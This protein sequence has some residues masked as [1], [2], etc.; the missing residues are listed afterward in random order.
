M[1]G[2]NEYNSNLDV[3]GT[4]KVLTVPNS[5]G[6]VLTYNSVSKE[7]STRTNAEIIVDLGL[8]T[9]YTA[10][11]H[12]SL[13]SNAITLT[14][15]ANVWITDS[16]SKDR[17]Y[18]GTTQ[19]T[20]TI[21]KLG[22]VGGV[23]SIKNSADADLFSVNSA[24]GTV[25]INVLSG[26]GNRLIQADLSGSIFATNIDPANVITT[27]NIGTYIPPSQTLSIPTNGLFSNQG[28]AISISSGN[29]VNLPSLGRINLVD[30]NDISALGSGLA[31]F[32]NS[33]G[34]SN[35]PSGGFGAG[36]MVVRNPSNNAGGNFA[37]WTSTGNV[38]E[39]KL[40][41]SGSAGWFG[42]E[43]VATRE[44][45][46]TQLPIIGNGNISYTGTGNITGG[47]LSTANQATNTS[48]TFDLTSQT[49]IDISLGVTA[50]SW[51]RGLRVEGL[52]VAIHNSTSIDAFTVR[53]SSVWAASGANRPNGTNSAVV[54]FT[55]YNS[56]GT[57]YGF[58]LGARNGRI[59]FVTEE[60]SVMSSW[61]ELIHA[62]NIATQIANNAWTITGNQSNLSGV[63]T[64]SGTIVFNGSQA[65]PLFVGRTGTSLNSN[66]AFGFDGTW[67]AYVGLHDPNTFV[68]GNSASMVLANRSM[69][70]DIPSGLLTTKGGF[71]INGQ[72]NASILLAG[73][74]Y[75]PVSDF[76]LASSVPAQVNLIQ[77]TG[78][79]ITG[80]Y[81]NLTISSTTLGTVTSVGAS[82]TG[83]ALSIVGSP[84]TNS[85]TLAFSWTGT[86]SQYVDGTGALVNFPTIPSQLVYTGSNGINVTGT[87]ISP[88]YG[89][90]S[91]TVAE[92]ND[93]RINNG[94]TAF[95][96][97]NHAGLYALISHIHTTAQVT[98]LTGYTIGTNVAI[99]ATD[100]LNV[101]LGKIQAQLN[102]K[103]SNTGTVTS[104]A[105]TVAGNAL[106]VG[107]S[108]IITSGT[109]AFT[110]AGTTSQYVDGSGTL[111][112]FPTIPSQLVYTGSNG[113]NVTGTVISPVYGTTANTVA[114][115]NDSRFH[116][117]VT[118]GT[119]NG[120]SLSTQVL[121]LALATTTTAG[122]MSNTD[123]TKLD[124]IASN[125]NN[126]VLPIMTATVAGG[127][128]VFSNT[129]QT[130][131][132][133]AV[134]AV[135]SRTYGV[136]LNSSNQLVVNI[137]WTNTTYASGTLTDLNTGTS[138]TAVLWSPLIL[139]QWITAKLADKV[140]KTTTI[141]FNGNTQNLSGNVNFTVP[142]YVSTVENFVVSSPMGINPTATRTRVNILT[143]IGS[144]NLN[145][146]NGINEGDELVIVTCGSGGDF[147]INMEVMDNCN[148]KNGTQSIS[149]GSTYRFW[150]SPQD[151]VWLTV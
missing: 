56:A 22:Q 70:L 33:V 130:V 97:G 91:G 92:G 54:N 119:A 38:N 138:T 68:I 32:F 100:S 26:T 73:G 64:T 80:T 106:T 28:G 109:L 140:D 46:T 27:G 111:Q 127:A 71:A 17:L 146:A 141:T 129:V 43:T 60:N 50:N 1:A 58:S 52:G 82:V 41:I 15:T 131:A 5:I 136:Q 44:W 85:G 4:I 30:F 34:S 110:W 89:T 122:A 133:T 86:A 37:L 66:V 31:S 51:G 45:V 29:T 124:G 36:I 48:F 16:T 115:G 132:A 74:G 104:V 13:V 148:N 144:G 61:S 75:R 18:F 14:P 95:S 108:P 143:N 118:L 24:G 67:N 149:L 77:G 10:G 84:I 7:I 20:D 105:S 57:T 134:S 113:I 116:N 94:Q 35:Y 12:I 99:S 125:A 69:W 150:W 72:T 88:V 76:A 139:T 49:K 128:M 107:G 103:T 8:N 23:F 98:A 147:N 114:Q 19:L 59:F 11:N 40:N 121:S 83:T 62:G 55:P 81:P 142:T 79:S 6:T 65:T 63:K 42:W 120:L 151:S 102:V 126:Y 96:W 93:N 25:R 90:S 112:T 87:V 53:N 135:A 3:Q 9:L 39:L 101:A 145:I 137:P 123:K 21:F 2:V 47:G 117:P 78:I